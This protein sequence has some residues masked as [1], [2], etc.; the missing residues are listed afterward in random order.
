MEVNCRSHLVR[1]TTTL[2][3]RLGVTRRTINRWLKL[4]GAPKKVDGLWDVWEWIEF[5]SAQWFYSGDLDRCC[6]ALKVAGLIN[7]RLPER[8]TRTTERVL[9][10]VI[11]NLLPYDRKTRREFHSSAPNTGSQ[12]GERP[13]AMRIEEINPW[14]LPATR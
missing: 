9:L 6:V 7:D 11:E 10:E 2:A 14:N 12:A 4:P 1:F 5:L 13:R 3:L 8:V